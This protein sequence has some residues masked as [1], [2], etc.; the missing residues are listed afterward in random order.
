MNARLNLHFPAF[1]LAVSLCSAA[2]ARSWRTSQIPSGST[3]GCAACHNNPS[4]GGSRTAFGEAVWAA[5]PAA[6]KGTT[7]AF[8][9]AA[10]AS[11]DSDGDG[12]GN[13]AELGDST[14]SGTV[15]PGTVPTNPG[16]APPTISSTPPTS[17]EEG[18]P[19]SYQATATDR[20]GNPF[21]F[22]LVSAPAWLSMTSAGRLSGTPPTGSA[23]SYPVSLR[24]TDSA[25]SSLGHSR[26]STTQSFSLAVSPAPTLT[27]S[28]LLSLQPVLL[29]H[30][31]AP[32]N[33]THANDGTGRLFI[34][35]QPGRIWVMRG[36]HVLPEPFLDLTARMQ[37]MIPA[38]GYSERGLLG[39]A[40]APGFHAPNAPGFRKFYVYYSAPS[41]LPA[42]TDP[43]LGTTDPVNHM[44]VLAEY[45]VS[46]TNPDAADPASHRTLL[47]FNQPQSNHNGGQLA[48]GPDGFLYIASG[49]GGG[50]EDSS[51]G[52]SGGT[53][54][55]PTN[56]LGN[57]QDLRRLLGKILRINP[58]GSNGP[59]GTY[60]IPG[61]NPFASQQGARPEIFAFGLR[62][63][64]RFSFD[65]R[66]GGTNRFF[67]A[68]VGQ[69]RIEE[70]NLISRGGNYGWRYREGTETTSFSSG[71]PTAPANLIAPI[72][73]YQHPGISPSAGLPAL[74][75]SV[76]GGYVYR[77]QAIPEL[78][79]RY[80]FGDYGAT[81]GVSSGRLMSLQ[82]TAPLSGRFLLEQ[83][84]PLAQGN[85]FALRV[86]TLGEDESGEL[87][88]GTKTTAGVLEMANGRP[89]GGVYRLVP[90]RAGNVTLTPTRD[91]TLFE[92][93][94]A[95][96]NGAGA[97]LFSG[98]TAGTNSLYH[99]RALLGFDLSSIP[100]TA[101]VD[102]ATLRLTMD[103]TIV[104]PFPF[105]LQPL[106]TPWSE[107]SSDAGNPGGAGTVAAPA[108]ATFTHASFPD[109]LW[110]NP[111][112]DF[113][114]AAS[115]TTSVDG[116]NRYAWSGPGLLADV[117]SWLANPAGNHGW[118]LRDP[119]DTTNR[120]SRTVSAKRFASRSHPDPAARPSLEI[121]WTDAPAPSFRESWLAQY[122]PDLLPGA[123]ANDRE[124]ADGDGL[125]NVLEYAFGTNPRSRNHSNPFD[126]VASGPE[127]RFSR[128]S[129]PGDLRW[130]LESS[131]N[132][133][134][135]SPAGPPV[136]PGGTFPPGPLAD[137]IEVVSDSPNEASPLR[138]VTLRVAPSPNRFL[139]L[140]ITRF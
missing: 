64:W 140:A 69:D 77:G 29:G 136:L 75:L 53:A 68:D 86:L 22:S 108:D 91:A 19:L 31:H 112:G 3:V 94:G 138:T 57:G 132:L 117:Q 105:Q 26:A 45:M 128:D 71:M 66:P 74:G 54:S 50:R 28:P 131:T 41:D 14:G 89:A 100:P 11:P 134:Q 123:P 65:S 101:R 44:S 139:R 98:V 111:G 113:L 46:A 115:S 51:A 135:W 13:G 12:V 92:E 2:Q 18:L 127:L 81:S 4:G 96:A 6:N 80:V 62:N 34:S 25:T 121:A 93:N 106:T 55:R 137:G 118:I 48:F 23:G 36:A 30:I 49:D 85:P 24:V 110:T 63:P 39:L 124:D 52:H 129:R 76:T 43:I 5:L 130:Q 103:K 84:I 107:G 72:A 104:G 99:R 47:R 7:A 90:V 59:G 1:A 73:Q 10:L 8:W 119:A 67:A 83:A 38:S 37:G 79:G 58:F 33:I 35:D 122:F 40:F 126:P 82:E 102:S 88:V 78:R 56:A 32:T 116:N 15:A 21:T 87:Y 61:D 114:P 27:P 17:A 125:P 42:E 120:P 109:R 20:E 9:S 70:I 60:G 133:L 95:L 97:W 16:N